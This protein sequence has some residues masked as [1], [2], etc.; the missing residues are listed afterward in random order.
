[1]KIQKILPKS[2]TVVYHMNDGEAV[3]NSW[4]F[5]LEG[6][7]ALN[8]QSKARMGYTPDQFFHLVSWA[9]ALNWELGEGGL[10][11]LTKPEMPEF[12][13]VIT[14]SVNEPFSE[15]RGLFVHSIYTRGDFG[16]TVIELMEFGLEYAERFSYKYVET[17][18]A[19]LSGAAKRLFHNKLGFSP[20][21]VI[22][23]KD[24]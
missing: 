14:Y 10:L 3:L 1:M 8:E 12:G 24:I 11:W 2:G 17:A 22:F 19:R 5:F 20:K 23:R 15:D 9:A 6:L 16:K 7:A 13:F 4:K 18:N 21:Y